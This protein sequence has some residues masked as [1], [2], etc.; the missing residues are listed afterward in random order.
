M[1]KDKAVFYN[2]QREHFELL[3]Q[4]VPVV[5]RVHGGNHPEFHEVRKLFGLIAEKAKTAG[6][7]GPELEQEFAQ[8]RA[9]SGHY[10]VPDDVC[11]SYEA[12]YKALV[13]LDEAFQSLRK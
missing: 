11:E 3:N 2:T 6:V 4:Y 10:T 13:Q 5:A 12:V 1:M 8:L 7:A 9:V